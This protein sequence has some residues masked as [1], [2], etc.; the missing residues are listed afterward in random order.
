MN[1]KRLIA[2]LTILGV[3]GLA[4]MAQAQVTGRIVTVDMQKIFDAYHKT[5]VARSKLEETRDQFTNELKSKQEDLKKQVEELNQLRAEQD[6]PEYTAEVREEKRKAMNEKLASMQKFQRDV[7]EYRRSH[8]RIL[9]EQSMRMRQGIL[10][11]ITEVVQKEAKDTGYML[12]I[13]RSGNTLNGM[14]SLVFSQENLDITPD[15]IKIL[16]KNAPTPSQ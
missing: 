2:V 10:K 15:I 6:R 1:M 16:N 9:E 8:Q 12:V 13:D 7:E 14:P 5:P 3:I 11:E 4:G